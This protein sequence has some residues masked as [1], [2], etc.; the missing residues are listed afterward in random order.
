[1]KKIA[2]L[3]IGCGLI[4]SPVHS[5]P[6]PDLTAN[7]SA[8]YY[9]I[10][11][12][13]T[14]DSTDAISA[15]RAQSDAR[16]R[17]AARE[18]LAT[19]LTEMSERIPNLRVEPNP[20]QTAP[21]IVDITGATAA[22]TE[23]SNEAREPL[24]RRFVVENAGLYG[25]TPDQARQLNV[26]ADYSNPAGN[27]SWVE[28]EQRING[29]PVF[30]GYLRAEITRDGR[31]W[32]TTGN[33]AAGLDYTRLSTTTGITPTAAAIAAAKTI[34]VKVS[35]ADLQALLPPIAPLAQPS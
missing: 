24:F 31:I 7:T 25:L 13:N 11:L 3:L 8:N 10:R 17:A 34:E 20:F 23:S 16:T 9:D 35:S 26:V 5:A 19:G 2:L 27:F 14:K 12:G 33:L 6:P 28:Y 30:Q 29:I 22:L 15:Y 1:M 18:R 32:R 21:E 4:A